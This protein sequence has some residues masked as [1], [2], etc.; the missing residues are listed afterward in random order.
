MRV[1]RPIELMA[2]CLAKSSDATTMTRIAAE[3]KMATLCHASI[4]LS[5]VRASASSP[6]V[7]KML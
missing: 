1:I 2:G 6:S 4:R 7:M 3:K 5:P